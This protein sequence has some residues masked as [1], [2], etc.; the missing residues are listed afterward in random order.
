M[1]SEPERLDTP[2]AGTV[3]GKIRNSIIA[4]M[5]RRAP[6]F[7]AL[8]LGRQPSSEAPPGK[9]PPVPV[10]SLRRVLVEQPLH[11]LSCALAHCFRQR[12]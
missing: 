11:T 5:G 7:P 1:R 8:Q 2:E 4:R 9:F 12:H 10:S 6:D 3:R